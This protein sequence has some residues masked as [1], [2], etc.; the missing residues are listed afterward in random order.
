MSQNEIPVPRLDDRF[1][2]LMVELTQKELALAGELDPSPAL[3][4]GVLA[5][6]FFRRAVANVALGE[7]R[8]DREAIARELVEL[9]MD[10]DGPGPNA[11]SNG[12]AR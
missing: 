11:A 1:F 6:T 4:V 10:D 2:N 12:G 3:A 8:T 9:A 7:G 5:R